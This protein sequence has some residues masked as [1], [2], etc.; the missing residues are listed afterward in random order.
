M[1]E[2]KGKVVDYDYPVEDN[3]GDHDGSLKQKE[4]AQNQ[5]WSGQ[6]HQWDDLRDEQDGWTQ[7]PPARLEGE[8]H[9]NPR[10]T[11]HKILA[12]TVFVLKK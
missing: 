6:V 3:N 1:M 7:Q 4:T 10:I 12:I 8:P 2:L 5:W 9:I 11:I